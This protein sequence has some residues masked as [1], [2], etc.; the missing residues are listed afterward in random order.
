MIVR[1]FKEE[2]VE[3]D[4]NLIVEHLNKIAVN[5]KFIVGENKYETQEKILNQTKSFKKLSKDILNETKNDL[6]SIFISNKAYD[7][8]Y[9]FHNDKKSKYIISSSNWDLYTTYSKNT[10]IVYMI[11]DI[12]AL[13][14]D[15]T[16]R[17]HN[18]SVTKCIYNFN[19]DKTDI[20]AGIIASVMCDS[21]QSQILEIN[22][23]KKELIL[24]DVINLLE[25]LKKSNAYDDIVEYWKIS[26]KEQVKIFFSYSHKD[27]EYLDEFKEYIKIFER[28]NLVER[29]DDNELVVGEKWDKTIKDKI[30][31]ADI[32]IFLLSSTSL[33]SDYIYHNELKVAFELNEMDEAYV[34]P[35]II[36][37]CLWDMTEFKSFQILPIDGKAVNSW[38]RREEAWT[39]VSRGLKKAIDNI[40]SAKQ[41]SLEKLQDSR[42]IKSDTKIGKIIESI[43]KSDTEEEVILKFLKIYSRW[44]FNIPRIINWGSERDGF[45]ILKN[46]NSSELERI[47]ES[48]EEQGQIISKSS[49]KNKSKLYKIK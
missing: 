46:I 16:H 12:L 10:G 22:D 43:K 17:H 1:L 37:D 8:N 39:S 41:N 3:V 23:P 4:L 40:I 26:Q 7:D 47:L 14:V 36:K 24:N 13:Y 30:Y 38:D 49:I 9:Y 44:W 2:D 31:S 15:D 5:V 19:W 42:D 21:C 33:A 25:E 34:I 11:I 35:I 29:W 27:R 6:V 45:R 48:L 18:D 28:N 20:H 32:I